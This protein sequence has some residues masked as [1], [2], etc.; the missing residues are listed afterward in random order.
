MRKRITQL[1]ARLIGMGAA[2]VA[3]LLLGREL[4]AEQASTLTSLTGEIAA[5]LVAAGAFA[6]DLLIHRAE[7]GGVVTPAGT[8]KGGGA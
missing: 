6:V 4:D 8:A 5:G 1:L 2:A 3:A 7:T